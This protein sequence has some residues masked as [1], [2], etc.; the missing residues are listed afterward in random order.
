M[1]KQL[2]KQLERGYNCRKLYN[3]MS[4]IMKQNHINEDRE[5][6]C[7]IKDGDYCFPI[8]MVRKRK[9]KIKSIILKKFLDN[10][11]IIEDLKEY[12]YLNCL[13]EIC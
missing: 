12:Y 6:V 10:T 8:Y 2:K 7:Y 9:K 3:I 5:T 4:G 11:E 13:G 1:L